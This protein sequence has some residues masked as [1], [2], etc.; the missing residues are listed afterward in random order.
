MTRKYGGTGLGLTISARLVEAMHGR[1]WVES[2]LGFG[3]SFH[4]TVPFGVAPGSLATAPQVLPSLPVLVVDDN[5]TNRRILTEVLARWG[6][7]PASAASG[8]EALTSAQRA[9]ED[10]VPFGLIITDVHMPGM[11]GFEL[12]EKLRESSYRAGAMILMLTS[13]ERPGDLSLARGL[14]VSH[15][16]TK[17]VRSAELKHMIADALGKESP[18]EESYAAPVPDFASSPRHDCSLNVL[19]AEDNLVNQRLAQRVLEK[20][21]HSVVVVTNGQDALEALK[22]YAFDLVLMDVQ[23]PGMD[24][25]EAT[26]AIRESELFGNTHIPIIALTAHAM[27]GDEEK[28]LAAGMD[29]YLSKP[30]HAA[31][32]FRV[33]QTYGK[34]QSLALPA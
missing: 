5:A 6:M 26:R 9:C 21:G 25:L 27:K 17:P 31:D 28:C 34:N 33:I 13:G 12:A 2:A 7:K 30:V 1:I 15:Y 3:S 32:L 18:F 16:L 19:L 24:G 4:F 23:M 20:H 10:G 29:A 14:G 8:L 22:H 11:D